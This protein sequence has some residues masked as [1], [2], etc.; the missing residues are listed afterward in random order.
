[1]W[2]HHSSANVHRRNLV[3]SIGIHVIWISRE[4]GKFPQISQRVQTG[5]GDSLS[6][7][8]RKLMRAVLHTLLHHWQLTFFCPRNFTN[9]IT[10]LQRIAVMFQACIIQENNSEKRVNQK[11]I[12]K[13]YLSWLLLSV[14]C[15][16]KCKSPLNV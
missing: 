15:L 11:D 4:D 1:M 6:L 3:I 9:V 8:N 14:E 10:P 12:R 7:T 16:Y 5:Q 2:S 13:P